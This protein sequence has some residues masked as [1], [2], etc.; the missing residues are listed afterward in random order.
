MRT[1]VTIRMYV[2]WFRHFS[3]QSY[4]NTTNINACVCVC[5]CG[6]QQKCWN[7]PP[8]PVVCLSNHYV[9]EF[10]SYLHFS[11]VV[12][13]PPYCACSRSRRRDDLMGPVWWVSTLPPGVVCF[14]TAHIHTHRGLHM[15]TLTQTHIHGL[16]PAES[17]L[18]SSQNSTNGFEFLFAPLSSSLHLYHWPSHW[19][20]R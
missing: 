9:L 5:L 15:R 3:L 4:I 14:L 19:H 16:A 10:C 2:I 1:Y 17:K 6:M 8:P 7:H 11:I 18:P 20:F 12:F 13:F